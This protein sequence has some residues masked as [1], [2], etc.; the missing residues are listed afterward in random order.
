M[1]DLLISYSRQDGEF[2]RRLHAALTQ[3]GRDVW[4]DFEDIPIS[5]AWWESIHD[6]IEETNAFV[7]VIS[8]ASVGSPICNLE[9]DEALR[10]HKRLI[11]IMLHPTKLEEG[12]E[13]ISRRTLSD[14]ALAVL[15]GREITEV[16]RNNWNAIA[17]HNWISFDRENEF[18][19]N[20]QRL[21]SALDTDLEYV[22]EH[23]RLFVRANDWVQRHRNPHLLLVGTEI[24][25]AES[26]LSHAV[27]KDPKPTSLHAEYI[28]RSRQN[29]NERQRRRFILLTVGFFVSVALAVLASFLAFY[30]NTQRTIAVQNANT[31]ATAQSEAV[32]QADVAATNAAAANINAERANSLLWSSYARQT[33]DDGEGVLALAL[34]LEAATIDDVPPLAQQTL[35][36]IAYAPGPRQRIL[37]GGDTVNEVA[38]SPNGQL[39]ALG[40]ANQRV[41]F[42]DLESGEVV[43]TFEDTGGLVSTLA[44]GADGRTVLVAAVNTL[45]L[46]DVE[47]GE[48]L[49]TMQHGTG[50]LVQSV[51]ISPDGTRA[52]SGALDRNAIL[53]DLE[54]GEALQTLSDH[55]DPVISVAFSP[56]GTQALSGS[57]DDTAILWDLAAGE[58][59]RRFQEQS[60]VFSV[61]F[62]PSG[63]TMVTG[64]QLGD[65]SYWNLESGERIHRFDGTS[66]VGHTLP[67]HQVAFSPQ[68]STVISGSEDGLVILWNV[69]TGAAQRVFDAHTDSVNSV[70]FSSNGDTA[71]SGAGDGVVYWWSVTTDAVSTRF[72]GEHETEILSAAYNP[73]GTELL[74]SSLDGSKL[75]LWDTSAGE[76][77]QDYFDPSRTRPINAVAFLPDGERFVTAADDGTVGVWDKAAGTVQTTFEQHQSAAISI[78]VSPDGT[79]VL[80]GD[81]DGVIYLWETET[82]TVLHMLS[83]GSDEN[84]H[85]RAVLSL[86]FSADGTQVLSGSEDRT[87]IL[88]DA[89]TGN[90]IR[91]FGGQN[92]RVL[93]VGFGNENESNADALYSVTNSDTLFV[94]DANTD[95]PITQ[96]GIGVEGEERT[97]SAAAFAAGGGALLVGRADGSVAL[98]DLVEGRPIAQYALDAGTGSDQISTLSFNAAG[99]AAAVGTRGSDLLQIRT[100]GLDALIAWAQENR[101]VT[102][103]NCT[104][105]EAYNIMPLCEGETL[106]TQTPAALAVMGG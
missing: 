26:W 21:L 62:S 87:M 48:V 99:D 31:A 81:E 57:E 46:F 52:L 90:A 61:A 1:T 79:R 89:A 30:A 88:W 51:A 94:W 101:Y 14:D 49:R 102:D 2:V 34:A 70:A 97:V 16:V 78:A 45:T 27:E 93:A 106:P 83:D 69:V 44:Y 91:T 55:I 18:E 76:V 4:V 92:G 73:D 85:R 58:V 5:A 41:L 72:G 56:D 37:T 53:W 9:I 19:R 7:F 67:V 35:A 64:T 103:F 66:G 74:V 68:G 105:R 60:G 65:L 75:L 36:E 10:N 11:P 84:G 28:T 100:L 24:N 54:T 77:I 40:L 13:V 6:A 32:F 80:S 71:L 3:R 38:F 12:L 39:A 17:R 20:V 86:M 25:D 43:S 104:E 23:T 42:V 59:V 33:L 96:L 22:K 29:A 95:T 8:P 63:R 15:D 47:T 50:T 98:W 82:G